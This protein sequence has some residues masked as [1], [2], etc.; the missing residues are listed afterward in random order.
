MSALLEIA[1]I[2]AIVAGFLAVLAAGV[3]RLARRPALAHALWLLVL[4]KLLTPPIIQ[5]P[6]ASLW[7]AGNTGADDERQAA[8]QRQA[9]D[10]P[11]NPNEIHA[12]AVA[13][14]DN[15]I[16]PAD[17]S[18]V[19]EEPLTATAPA[20]VP[21]SAGAP[22]ADAGSVEPL[23][24]GGGSAAA[25]TAVVFNLRRLVVPLLAIVWIAGSI[26]IATLAVVRIARFRRLLKHGAAAP[27]WLVDEVER[28]AKQIGLKR[29]PATLLVP[30]TVSP[31]LWSLGGRPQIILPEGLL[32]RMDRQER[33][34][35]LL[36]ELC[37]LKRR[38]NWVRLLELAAGCCYWWHPAVWWARRE[39]Q[40]SEEACCDAWVVWHMSGG[41][42]PYAKALLA[43]V[44]F[45]SESQP[46][47]HPVASGFGRVE[48]L[49]RRL[50]MIMQGDTPRRLTGAGRLAVLF[51]AMCS[52]PLW[53]TVGQ[54]PATEPQ[55]T[56]T[57]N[58]GTQGGSQPPT[59]AAVSKADEKQSVAG[60]T[61][62][63]SGFSLPEPI[64]FEE[65]AIGLSRNVQ[66]IRSTAFSN[67]GR[68]LAA[69]HGS[70]G[71]EGTVRIWDMQQRKEIAVWEEPTGIYSVH[72]S[73]DRRLVLYSILDDNLVK[74]R[75]I[76]SGEEVLKIAMGGA[77]ARVRFSPDGKTFV[78]ATT[79]G[80]LKLWDAKEGNELKSLASLAFNLQC[81]A[82]SRDGK[83]IVAGGGPF[84][85]DRFGW[86]GVW[87][88]ASGKQ[89]AEMKDMPDSVLGI[90][91]SPDGKLVA[92]AGRDRV[93]RLWR[94]ET[95]ELASTLSGHQSILEWVD[96]SPDGKMLASG[97]YDRTARLWEVESGREV[98][99]LQGHSGDVMSARFSPDGKTVATAGQGGIVRLWN[100]DSHEQIAMLEPEAAIRDAQSTILSMACSPDG[101]TIASAH[102]DKTVRLRDARTGKLKRV[103]SEDDAEVSSVAFSPDSKILAVGS[104]DNTV[105]LWK[106]TGNGEPM[107]L[108]GHTDWVLSVAFAPDGKT[109]ASGSRDNTIRLWDLE[110]GKEK[111]VLEGHAQ[112]V[113]CLAFSPD[114]KMLASGSTDETVRLWDVQKQ[115]EISK[116]DGRFGGALAFS[117]DGKTLASAGGGGTIILRDIETGNEQRI[118]SR[119]RSGIWCLAFSPRGRTLAAGTSD[120][121]VVFW[122]PASAKERDASRGHSEPVTS[123]AFL[124]DTSALISGSSDGTLKL[125]RARPPAFPPIATLPATDGKNCRFVTFSRDG[126]WLIAGGITKVIKVWDMQ[127][128][129]V[130][131]LL[132]EHD[133]SSTCAA[134]SPDGKVLATGTYAGRIFFWDVASGDRIGELA[135][136]LEYSINIDFSPDGTQ[137]A[138]ATWSKTVSVWDL[139]SKRNLWTSDEQSLPVLSV[140]FSP[141]GKTL[142]TTTGHW[143]KREELG[144]AKLWDA[145]TGKELATLPG[146]TD[147]IDR[148]CF[149]PDGR[150]LLT[151]CADSKLRVWD[152]PSRRLVSTI[153]AP[154]AVQRVIFL[155]DGKTVVTGQYGGRLLRWDLDS[156][157]LLSEYEGPADRVSIFELC[158]SPDGSLLATANLDGIVRLWPTVMPGS[159]DA[160][161][162]ADIVLG[163]SN[164]ARYPEDER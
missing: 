81:V 49:K 146:H 17:P 10:R 149:S 99:M 50:T 96:F 119:H 8:Q 95:G 26:L 38:D 35:I 4:L 139:K 144:E 22:A 57:E 93:A 82:F 132:E 111:A 162:S 98:A 28:L 164:D 155:P 75:A 105:K 64:K 124:P 72:I 107:R 59:S 126:K 125:W 88:I 153:S 3:G 152:V 11:N 154:N 65:A 40:W 20:P 66:T 91:I 53:P 39:I 142:A 157:E 131:R 58:D 1:L 55:T 108:E 137:L 103:L 18:I 143:Q 52:L 63:V 116:L 163:W 135:T 87:E 89:I 2:N 148:A 46:A 141:D 136:G 102:Q 44:D 138:V 156:G 56:A 83:W 147:M 62:Q 19:L 133:C 84:G 80:A 109:V 76:E 12:G 41:G 92:T 79:R 140:V 118:Q 122:D 70:H 86:A 90:A 128:G 29:V 32:A 78:T 7:V 158:Q 69:A 112:M 9:D 37:H 51:V 21:S 73:P 121:T 130:S 101:S 85:E 31:L 110:T 94:A 48:S 113:R 151:A 43:M 16:Q 114:G 159:P 13:E 68:L 120:G 145:A 104:C 33:E 34:A 160:R 5:I 161:T 24:T 74:I 100:V 129:Q 6:V 127:T 115:S 97:S 54:E 45:L 27:A 23:E 71:T 60:T 134:I 123:M 47:V 61:K 36:H 150:L 42:R 25:Q 77:P 67:D 30:D 106:V 15:A 14:W 117:P